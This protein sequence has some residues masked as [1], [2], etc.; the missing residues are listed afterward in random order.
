VKSGFSG[1]KG[2]S[3]ATPPPMTF[4]VDDIPSVPQLYGNA[5]DRMGNFWFAVIDK[6]AIDPSVS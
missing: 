6:S 1:E 3:D 5:E 4:S 2:L